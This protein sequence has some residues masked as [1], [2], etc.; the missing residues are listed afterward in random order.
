[1]VTSLLYGS[2]DL[3]V[4]VEAVAR[5]LATELPDPK[6]VLAGM[7]LTNPRSGRSLPVDLLIVT[8]AG[9]FAGQDGQQAHDLPSPGTVA[10]ALAGFVESQQVVRTPLH[11]Y[12]FWIGRVGSGHQP[13]ETIPVL[14]DAAAVRR[15]LEAAATAGSSLP[16][17]TVNLLAGR[18]HSLDKGGRR[19]R[20]SPVSYMRSALRD[21]VEVPTRIDAALQEQIRQPFLFRHKGPILP[22]DVHKHLEKAMFSRRHLI[23]G[24]DYSKIV[25]NEFVVELNPDNLR[26]NF[27]PIADS[28]IAGWRERLLQTLNTS[29]ERWGRREYQFG[30]PVA[31]RLA[32]AP[33]LDAG[34]VRIRCRVNPE[35]AGAQTADRACLGLADGSRVWLLE[36][37]PV[38]I[39]RGAGN[40]IH[41][42]MPAVQQARLV[43]GQHAY[44]TF[45]DGHYFLHDGSP[46]G[47]RSTNGTFVNGREVGQEGR[48][49]HDGDTIT[50]AALDPTDPGADT[51]G[52]VTLFFHDDCPLEPA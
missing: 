38:T 23:E 40:N 9:I 39:G 50:L 27:E 35:P 16:P 1:M 4:A 47:K 32:R 13:E 26:R 43:S 11:L 22:A 2:R 20:R 17:E 28:V 31:L 3:S 10:D 30:G 21:L 19:K 37:T 51:P 25:P 7:I 8:P 6:S 44:V 52:T 34:E 36:R 5:N 46:S 14:P 48:R 41:L 33:E 29:N 24:A 45:E 18:L 49:L 42:E 12:G 15:Y